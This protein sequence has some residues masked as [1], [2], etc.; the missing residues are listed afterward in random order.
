MASS[1]NNVALMYEIY[2]VPAAILAAIVGILAIAWLIQS[3]QA[4]FYPRRLLNLLLISYVTNFADLIFRATLYNSILDVTTTL[5]IISILVAVGQRVII[6][7]NY[8]FIG[9]I[10][11][12]QSS[13][14]RAINIGTLL[15]ALISTVL[16]SFAGVQSTNPDTIEN[17][18]RLR[19]IAAAIV[20][21]LTFAFYPIWFLSKTF[22][23]M[24]K[25]AIVL[26]LISSLTCLIVAIYTMI[27]SI[28]QYYVATS[29]QLM[30]FYIFQLTPILIALI[31]WVIFHPI[32]SLPRT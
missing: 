18:F 25:Q 29:Q 8:V 13:F 26:L 15:V 17:S 12:I 27:I 22:K 14:A 24:T 20:L 9:Q 11:G 16:A 30:W 1:T 2:T 31:T 23:D 5:I 4:S 10:L 28:P 32:R 6:I 21:F 7:A 19:Q 3:I